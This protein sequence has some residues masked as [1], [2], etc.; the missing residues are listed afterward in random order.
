MGL[1]IKK[2]EPLCVSSGV[3]ESYIREGPYVALRD[4][5][6]EEVIEE[7][8]SR[9]LGTEEEYLLL[10]NFHEYLV[11]PRYLE[12]TPCRDIHLGELGRFDVRE[13]FGSGT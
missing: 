11:T 4:F 7:F 8:K 6:F 9:A 2:G 13:V 1:Y 10:S 3:Y 5:E 12:R